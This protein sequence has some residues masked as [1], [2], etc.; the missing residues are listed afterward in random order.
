MASI[1]LLHFSGDYW[2]EMDLRRLLSLQFEADY[3]AA[4]EILENI[5]QGKVQRLLL[6][7]FFEAE[8]LDAALKGCGVAYEYEGYNPPTAK[9]SP[10]L[11]SPA[12]TQVLETVERLRIFYAEPP[13]RKRLSETMVLSAQLLLIGSP[14][15]TKRT[16]TDSNRALDQAHQV[17]AKQESIEIE[18][19]NFE[20]RQQFLKLLGDLGLQYE[21]LQ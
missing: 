14:P 21:T 7:L 8:M 1:K 3:L 5:Q 12:P 15:N 10:A 9:R 16:S 11:Q 13:K 20:A 6:P 18:L 2:A 17:L 19:R 4:A